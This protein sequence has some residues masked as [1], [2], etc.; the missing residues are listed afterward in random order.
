VAQA[1]GVTEA[2]AEQLLQASAP[3]DDA[4]QQDGEQQA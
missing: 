4:N 2:E 1:L 3:A